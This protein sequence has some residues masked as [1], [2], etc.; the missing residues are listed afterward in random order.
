MSFE[1][2]KKPR[3]P[4]KAVGFIYSMDG[5]PIGEC[6]TL[7]ISESGAKIMLP[8]TDD[9]PPEFLLSLSRDGRVRRRCQLKWRDGD[10]IGVRFAVDK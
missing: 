2:R 9:L 8:L 4:I 3:K 1:H 10:K 6:S 5:W 7:D